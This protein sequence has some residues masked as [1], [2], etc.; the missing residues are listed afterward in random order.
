MAFE[1][2]Q[3]I[4]AELFSVDDDYITM[5]TDFYSDLYADS[6]DMFE[7][8]MI[9]EEEFD[10]NDNDKEKMVDFRTVGQVVDYLS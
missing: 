8:W 4:L 9:L 7:F 1:T 3:P 6:L 10:L 5:E 2:L